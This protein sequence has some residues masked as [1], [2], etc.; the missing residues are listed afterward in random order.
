MGSLIVR[1]AGD[2]GSASPRISTPFVRPNSRATSSCWRRD[3]TRTRSTRSTVSDWITRER[4]HVRSWPRR[5]AARWASGGLGRSERMNPADSI[6]MSSRPRFRNSARN[7]SSAY[8]LR[9]ML[10][11]QITRIVG[12]SGTPASSRRRRALRT[13]CSRRSGIRRTVRRTPRTREVKWLS[14]AE[15][16]DPDS[17][18]V[19]AGVAQSVL[20]CRQP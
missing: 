18:T 6:R 4:C 19:V 15:F 1:V 8:G 7:T 20:G 5:V 10:P 13:G 3:M 9:Q 14:S 11:R 16:G 12:D 17:A 2:P